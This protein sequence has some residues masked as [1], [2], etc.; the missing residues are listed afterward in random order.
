MSDIITDA[1]SV[2]DDMSIG[3][4]IASV[5]KC[6]DIITEIEQETIFLFAEPLP[7]SERAK[8][9]IQTGIEAICTLYELPRILERLQE[10]PRTQQWFVFL[11]WVLFGEET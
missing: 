2:S 8:I 1:S 4:I 9:W 3:E 7:G 6:I 5:D 10:V 11:R